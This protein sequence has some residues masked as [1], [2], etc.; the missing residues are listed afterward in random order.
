MATLHRYSVYQDT[1]QGD[2]A[3]ALWL[4]IKHLVLVFLSVFVVVVVVV[5]VVSGNWVLAC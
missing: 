4:L 5:V 1:V 2:L 3:L